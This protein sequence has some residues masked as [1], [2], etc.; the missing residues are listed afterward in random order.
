MHKI[1]KNK[2]HNSFTVTVL[3]TNLEPGITMIGGFG[4]GKSSIRKPAYSD[5][6]INDEQFNHFIESGAIIN[7]EEAID[8]L[9][10]KNIT[11]DSY[12]NI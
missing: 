8:S 6:L 2:S 9:K 4:S 5:L 1:M 10:R 11:M 7:E 12:K 3:D